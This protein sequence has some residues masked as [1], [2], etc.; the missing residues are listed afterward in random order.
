[1]QCND[2]LLFK[3]KFGRQILENIHYTAYYVIVR[4]G[5]VYVICIYEFLTNGLLENLNSCFV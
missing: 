3:I 1:M 4:F 2:C 5:I